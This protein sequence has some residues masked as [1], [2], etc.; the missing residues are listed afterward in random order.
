MQIVGDAGVQLIFFLSREE[1]R[2]LSTS[3]TA[4]RWS[5]DSLQG[6]S[7]RQEVAALDDKGGAKVGTPGKSEGTRSHPL[8]RKLGW[9]R[10]GLGWPNRFRPARKGQVISGSAV[11]AGPGEWR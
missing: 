9:G 5:F 7:F 4:G 1:S 2:V 11:G 10:A 3:P 6:S 8:R